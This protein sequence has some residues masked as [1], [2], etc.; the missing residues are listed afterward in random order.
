MSSKQQWSLIAEMKK[1]RVYTASWITM[2]VPALL[3][4]ITDPRPLL[5]IKISAIFGMVIMPFTYHPTL[6]VAADKKV[7]GKHANNRF[8]QFR[9]RDRSEYLERFAI[10]QGNVLRSQNELVFEAGPSDAIDLWVHVLIWSHWV[11][12]FSSSRRIA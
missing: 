8:W 5:L 2:L 7:M 9:L 11:R 1:S 10:P 12:C 6:R 4:A 3:I